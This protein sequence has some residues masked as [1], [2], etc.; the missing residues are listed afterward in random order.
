MAS[1]CRMES[2]MLL[3]IF[4]LVSFHSCQSTS[5]NTD[6]NQDVNY[7][8]S[9]LDKRLDSFRVD[10]HRSFQKQHRR[11][12]REVDDES[13]L[14]IHLEG[15]SPLLA[16][17][18]TVLEYFFVNN[19]NYM[20]VGRQQSADG[21]HRSTANIY[22]FDQGRKIFN[23][24]DIEFPTD[25]V[26]DIEAFQVGGHTYI[27]VANHVSDTG[28]Y[29]CIS[30]IYRFDASAVDSI[31][32]VQ[33][34]LTYGAADLTFFEFEG[35][36]YL[37]LANMQAD[38]YAQYRS[39]MYVYAF[40][41]AHFDQV[42]SVETYGASAIAVVEIEWESYIIVAQSTDNGGNL[43]IGTI[44][45]NF[46]PHTDSLIKVQ[47]LES[48]AP[49]DLLSFYLNYNHYLAVANYQQ[50]GEDG[51]LDINTD[52]IIYWWTGLQYIEYQ[53]IPT[54]GASQ[55]Q[56]IELPNGDI[57]LVLSSLQDV[58]IYE[59]NE[60][61]DWVPAIEQLT[62][63]SG[64]EGLLF[65]QGATLQT[66]D[67]QDELLLIVTD[68]QMATNYYQNGVTN[69]FELSL[70]SVNQ[71]DVTVDAI[72]KCIQDVESSV[73]TL[74]ASLE[75]LT[76][77]LHDSLKLTGDQEVL[78]PIVFTAT[79]VTEE[80]LKV[81]NLTVQDEYSFTIDEAIIATGISIDNRLAEIL[82]LKDDVVT[83]NGVEAIN[84][85]L[86][87]KYPVTSVD[88][89]V[90]LTYSQDG[91]L[92]DID[93]QTLNASLVWLNGGD[94]ILDTDVTFTDDVRI[95]NA[96][97]N[98]QGDVNQIAIPGNVMTLGEDQTA[99]G[100]LTFSNSTSFAENLTVTGQVNGLDL[101]TD[102]VTTHLNHI[103]NGQKTIS[104]DFRL[105]NDAVVELEKTVDTVDLSSF[106]SLAIYVTQDGSITGATTFDGLVNIE[107][108]LLTD[109]VDGSNVTK[110]DAAAVLRYSTQTI[111]GGKVFEGNFVSLSDLIVNGSLNSAPVSEF[112]LINQPG[113]N[114]NTSIHFTNHLFVNGDIVI[115][116]LLNG[117]N[118][119]QDVVLTAGSQVIK[120]SVSFT[121]EIHVLG[122]IDMIEN[123][124]LAGVDISE[125]PSK[126]VST[127]SQVLQ[128]MTGL[129][130][131]TQSVDVEGDVTVGQFINSVNLTE[132][133]QQI[134][135]LALLQ[136]IDLPVEI[137]GTLVISGNLNLVN[138]TIDGYQLSEDL[139]KLDDVSS[140]EGNK[141]FEEFVLING[142]LELDVD[143]NI[144]GVDLL[145]LNRT[146]I[147]LFGVQTI[148]GSVA[149]RDDVTMKDNL[150]I[151]KL[152]NGLDVSVDVVTL[153]GNQN[154]TAEIEF[155]SLTV[156]SNI[157]T[158]NLNVSDEM[159]S[160]NIDELY[161]SAVMSVGSVESILSS[162]AFDQ[163]IVN[164]QL[165]VS[166]TIDQVNVQHLEKYVVTLSGDQTI[167]GSLEFSTGVEFSQN[168][169]VNGNVSGIDFDFFITSV[170]LKD[171][172]GL[173]FGLKTFSGNMS[174]D[175]NVPV[176][177]FINGVNLGGLSQLY[178][179]RTLNQTLSGLKTFSSNISVDNVYLAAGAEVNDIIPSADLV[180]IHSGG[181]V[182]DSQLWFKSS[183]EI[184]GDVNIAKTVNEIHLLQL[185]NSVV[186]L[187]SPEQTITGKWTLY[188]GMHVDG[189]ITMQEYMEVNGVD[190]SELADTL[191]Q[192][193]HNQTVEIPTIFKGP[194]TIDGSVVCLGLIGDVD[195]QFILDD[196]VISNPAQTISG[197]KYLTGVQSAKH[198]EVECEL[199]SDVV[200]GSE[201]LSH[202]L[203]NTV[204]ISTD[205]D[206]VTD[207]G[208]TDDVV[209]LEHVIVEGS[210]DGIDLSSDAVLK[211][212]DQDL[213]A[214]NTFTNGFHVEGNL[215]ATGLIDT[216]NVAVLAASVV[217]TDVY[218]VIEGAW[219]FQNN[220]LVYGD[221]TLP[222]TVNGIDIN[223][224]LVT[225]TGAHEITS[226]KTFT[227]DVYIQG[228]LL[229]ATV[230]HVNLVLFEQDI[231]HLLG[232]Y[233]ITADKIFS[234]EVM[235]LNDTTV[236]GLVDGIDV[237][238]MYYDHQTIAYQLYWQ[239]SYLND[240]LREMCQP[241]NSL[242]Y[243]VMRQ[244][245]RLS[246]F[247]EETQLN[248]NSLATFKFDS[249]HTDGGLLLAFTESSEADVDFCI[250]TTLYLCPDDEYKCYPVY[251]EPLTA[252][253][254][255]ELFEFNGDIFIALA[256]GDQ[257][258]FCTGIS[259]T[260][261]EVQI[262]KMS[263][264]SYEVRLP[265]QH[266]VDTAMFVIN[267]TF[268]VA[269]ANLYDPTTGNKDISSAV[270]EYNPETGNFS[271]LQLIS[272]IGAASVTYLELGGNSWLG[273]ACSH[274]TTSSLILKWNAATHQ[275]VLEAPILTDT[276]SDVL[277]IVV[278]EAP[279]MIFASEKVSTRHGT[280][281]LNQP[282][283]V[284]E[285]ST[286]LEWTLKQD[287]D[288]VGI[289]QLEAFL[290]D[291]ITY[292]LGVSS[293]GSIDIFKW[294]GVGQFEFFKSVSL[295]GVATVHPFVHWG[296]LH[297]A[298]ARPAFHRIVTEDSRS[299][300]KA[301]IRGQNQNTLLETL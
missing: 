258:T 110:M 265:A 276:A 285:Y 89:N 207:V 114:I 220:I 186:W 184:K 293:V 94:Q 199:V 97:L 294:S 13:D 59:L 55:W 67:T 235:V 2:A 45:Y 218:Q 209:F 19:N 179:S 259:S 10:I 193:G 164:D 246:F 175:G 128:I 53:R 138:D 227:N 48:S 143:V 60:D 173:I 203:V 47:R 66:V 63:V 11:N 181:D 188:N 15:I 70:N 91:L 131:F 250:G 22:L 58:I 21:S 267:G 177:K 217:L 253:S 174:V 117:M 194:V 96:H 247:E 230:N 68:K 211:H 185:Y 39:M 191:V 72:P 271:E 115:L 132:V 266:A 148:D 136:V 183:L 169:T 214:E 257:S 178:L 254:S 224:T 165:V 9:Y 26:S 81:S 107:G 208:F 146:V 76:I 283:S 129:K 100:S 28:T 223:E 92:N 109:L 20:I 144:S 170:V 256:V 262:L 77:K 287:I 139:I 40:S 295:E 166:D 219:Q 198:L 137:R 49:K 30:Y 237:Q 200:R 79:V 31:S 51:V 195:L 206:I 290:I 73:S 142:D 122:D 277:G 197:E 268:F 264:E 189:N 56:D 134:L 210:T 281:D 8:K 18:I 25:G 292:L 38:G 41:G 57:L 216:V 205:Q 118:L 228:D 42:T 192:S 14:S 113:Q 151:D 135:S 255:A 284:Y 78:G 145:E 260:A 69:V 104:Q 101:S 34:I 238:Q 167:L 297:M 82:S 196:A 84:S 54:Q 213:T 158:V 80:I 180:L 240:T 244:A 162:I 245:V 159:N 279:L 275:F 62:S 16:N 301:I 296:D 291:E 95:M 98:V 133:Q 86:V 102:V 111:Y 121:Q 225:L 241:I 289:I 141:I 300:V 278:E 43:D 229:V 65:T 75:G 130:E 32:E 5:Y 36:G 35:D 44:V 37:V 24:T 61:G 249:I 153:T 74:T 161:S 160:V 242:Q 105:K 274:E 64:N 29:N 171:T 202:L 251:D 172:D 99:L 152:L 52:S 1:N 154:I 298:V 168:L 93:V 176:D 147:K 201:T 263:S 236:L 103:I 182:I 119:S 126:T 204:T 233:T 149:I 23:K 243:A 239:I 273:F 6:A 288:A 106:K 150:Y 282:I 272:T 12:R 120:G 280:V 157:Q 261:N 269:V 234:S 3:L 27:A 83:I 17:N 123:A 127:S 71:T 87:F 231:V 4:I 140:I 124:T 88:T 226:P 248:K 187:Q 90:D 155:E 108:Q 156:L 299:F 33:Q 163:L 85:S 222:G 215:T 190:I 116:N 270:F 252:A 7:L 221:I 112:V 286:T 232:N 50:A 212:S 46:D 125:L